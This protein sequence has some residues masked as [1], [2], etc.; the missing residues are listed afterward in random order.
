MAGRQRK[1]LNIKRR[2]AAEP[3]SACDTQ[4]A[5]AILVKLVARAFAADNP[6]LSRRREQG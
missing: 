1:R 4:A 6:E 2:A 3:M 5:E